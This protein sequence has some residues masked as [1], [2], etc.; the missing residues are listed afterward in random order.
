MKIAIIDDQPILRMAIK[1]YLSKSMPSSKFFEGA[2]GE[3][4]LKILDEDRIDVMLLDLAMP[5]MDGFEF[6]DHLQK[7]RCKTFKIIA[8]TFYNDLTVVHRLL[9]LGIDGFLRKDSHI[10]LVKKAIDE[11]M[12]NKLFFSSEFGEK[13][14]HL[15][16]SGKSTLSKVSTKERQIIKF[17]AQ[18]RTSKEIASELDYTKR[19]IDTKKMRIEKKLFA[20]NV[21]E[22]ISIA[23]RIGILRI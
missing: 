15:M 11:V 3:D 13:A 16:Q 23:Y 1:E 10:G 8:F 17:I 6:L 9:R 4:A 2:N 7:R 22:L 21:A 12:D 18:G 19:T 20:R 5:E 14:L